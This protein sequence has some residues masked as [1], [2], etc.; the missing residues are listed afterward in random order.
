MITKRP[1][2]KAIYDSAVE[3]PS[4]LYHLSQLYGKENAATVCQ[5]LLDLMSSY[6][7][8]VPTN[9]TPDVSE[10]DAVLI[11]YGDMIRQGDEKP[12]ITLTKFLESTVAG[13]VSSVHI[14]P[15]YPWTSDD[16]FSV[17]DYRQVDPN[18]GEWADI[19]RLS[20]SF[21]MMFDAVIN[22]IS[23]ESEWFK[24]FLNQEKPFVD[25]FHV[26]DPATDLTEVFRPRSLPLLTPFDTSDG[27]TLHVWTTFSSDQIDLNYSNP[28]VFLAIV[29]VLLDYVCHG[30]DFIRLDAIGFMWKKVGTS[31]IHLPQT[32][33]AIQLMRTVLSIMA[34]H[35]NLI[36]ETNV[37]HE[38][39]VSYFGDGTNEAQMVYNFSLPPLTLHTFHTG[40]STTLSNWASNLKLPSDQV[41]FFNFLASHD[42]IGVTPAKGLISDNEILAMAN[43]AKALGGE[44]SYK[45]NPDG[46][47]SPYEL[48]IN[49]MDALGKPGVKETNRTK[50]D[51]FLA[52][53]A[54]MLV[55]QGVPGIYFH[56]LFGSENWQ[57]GIEETGQKRSINREKLRY[58]DVCADLNDINSTRSQVFYRFRHMIAVRSAEPA[59]SP[60]GS[61]KIFQMNTGLFCVLRGEGADGVFCIQNVTDQ[62]ITVNLDPSQI[63]KTETI[64]YR[65]I[66][67]NE[68]FD[69]Q[70]EVR[71]YGILWLK[72]H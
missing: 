70:V 42:G 65:N 3:R 40:N 63:F 1:S 64:W 66:I 61:Q 46:S 67:N 12:L 43:R 26:V 13:T 37:P 18:L 9:I 17:S 21:R 6:R 23:S 45:A 38:Q 14:L 57:E 35:V 11:T 10:K 31:C 50:A 69:H 44:V 47:E 53:Q 22:H 29:D 33:A 32:H 15:F 34:P 16:G 36:T 51:R 62:P 72:L 20:L 8:R 68:I 39:N 55:L 19:K 54:I 7:T 71:P 49:Y 28:E 59:F 25:W 5:R 4:L 58:V 30:A 41:T 56:S 48:N 27:S 52:S 24:S 2:K 60:Y